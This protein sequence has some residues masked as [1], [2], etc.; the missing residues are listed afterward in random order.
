M[1][2]STSLTNHLNLVHD[3]SLKADENPK[4]LDTLLNKL[5]TADVNQESVRLL[6]TDVP[7]LINQNI[8]KS[9]PLT[10]FLEA[11]PGKTTSEALVV[12]RESPFVNLNASGGFSALNIAKATETLGPFTANDGRFYWYDFLSYEKLVPVY[13]TG[14]AAPLMLI[15]LKLSALSRATNV[16][17]LSKGS[18]WLRADL[19]ATAAGNAKYAGFKISSGKLTLSKAIGITSDTLHIT[20]EVTFSLELVLDNTFTLKG[21]GKCGSDSRNA[22]IKL[23]PSLNLQYAAKKVSVSEMGASSW[24]LYG[25]K[26]QFSYNA[27]VAVYNADLDKILIPLKSDLPEFS[28]KKK[29]SEFFDISGNALVRDSVW[30]LSLAALDIT[31]PFTIRNNG[32]LGVIC[33]PGLSSRWI[34]LDAN[35]MVDLKGPYILAEPG[36][37]LIHEN[38]ADFKGLKENYKLWDLDEQSGIKAG[39]A[40]SFMRKRKLDYSCAAEGAEGI[41]ALADA[42]IDADKPIKADGQPVAPRSKDS[43]YVKY[44]TPALSQV[45][46][47]DQDMLSENE[48]APSEQLLSKTAFSEQ[49]KAA[50]AP[51]QFALEN[52]YLLATPPAA[53]LLAGSFDIDNVLIKGKLTILYG[54][55]DLVPT[56]PHPYTSASLFTNR[57]AIN[58][59]RDAAT[60]NQSM[61]G[62]LTS[63]CNWEKSESGMA[64]VNV[65]F[66]LLY[67][68]AQAIPQM[69][70]TSL[71]GNN[72]QLSGMDVFTSG[73]VAEN[74]KIAGN[75]LNNSEIFRTP[76]VFSLLDLSTNYDL[77]G[78]SMSFN[79]VRMITE[80]IAKVNQQS[81]Q[82]VTIEKMNLRTPMA[83]LNGFTLPHISWEPLVNISKPDISA[84]PE[85]GIL[86]FSDQGPSTI[87]SQFDTQVIDIDPMKYIK[88]F[89]NN[90]KSAGDGL[91]PVNP[92]P[93]QKNFVSNILF[94]LPNGK[95]SLANLTPYNPARAT[96]NNRHL[97]FIQPEFEM[98]NLKLK[99]GLQF[100]I[101]ANK[102]SSSDFPPELAGLTIQL[103]N[104]IDANG[105]SLPQSILGESVHTIFNNVFA[106]GISAKGVPVTHIDFSG[107]GAST[108]SN[109][110]APL[111]K[112]G[113]IA[114]VKFD[115]MR[116]RLSHEVVQAVS[117]IYPYGI[118]VVRTIT[119]Y[120]RN[121]AIIFREDSG[122]VAKSPGTFDFS[123]Q[124]KGSN[125]QKKDFKN[126]YIFHPGLINGLFEVCNIK[127]VESDYIS[128]PYT[129]SG[130]DYYSNS[131]SDYV[132]E[133]GTG[134]TQIAKFVGV[135]FDA[136]ADLDING[137]GQIKKVPGKQFKG[138]L[139][140]TPQ[141]V[142]IPKAVFNEL[143]KR[144]QNS[145]GG[146]VDTEIKLGG[147][148]Q[149]VQVGRLDVSA[150]YQNDNKSDVIF[151]AAAR[152]S[153][154]LPADGSW[155]IV[156]LDKTSGDVQPITN[157]QSVPIIREGVRNQSGPKFTLSNASQV[158]K[159]TPPD[160]LKNSAANFAKRF[161]YIQNTGTQKLLLTDPSYDSQKINK[162]ISEAPL[163]AD[164][165]RLLNSK[166]PFPNLGNAIKI[167]N[168]TNSL[169]NVLENGLSKAIN[170]FKLPDNFT[171]DIIGKDGD[172]FRMYIKYQSDAK[173]GTK[174]NTLISYLTDSAA[175]GNWKND[176]KDLSIVVDLASFKSLM[177]ISGDFSAKIAAEPGIGSGNAPQLKL[178]KPLEK[179]YQILEFLDNLDPT[180]AVEAVQRGL[181]I[182]MS[183][184]A[185]SWDYKFKASKEIPFVKFPFDPINYNSPTTPLKL[186]AYFKIGCY[187]NQ[188]I[189]IPNTIDQLMPSAGAFLE[190]G[191]DLRVMCVSL[192]AATIYATGRAE[193]GLAADLKSS[194]TLYF[195]FGFGV[196]LC[197]GLPVIGSV[198]VLYMVGVDMSLNTEELIVGAFIY[199]RGR[200]EIFGGIVTITI[201]IEAAGKIQKQLGGGPTS[202]I[203][204][205]TFALDISIFWVIDINFTETWEETRQIA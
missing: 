172:P 152:G 145:L 93:K 117:M 184:S 107:Y 23:P 160:A 87:F 45:M 170:D 150:S 125:G 10:E 58:T 97:D 148:F 175:G 21:E 179:I 54:L 95:I 92:D 43:I 162:L 102:A 146:N 143:M 204:M 151:V 180:N 113:D 16:Y 202:C 51:Y 140:L 127:E 2:K 73:N 67:N 129:P 106:S 46:V 78:V 134:N 111:A 34:G 88:R 65:D 74:F 72:N 1:A 163:L 85:E 63:V 154:Q 57:R 75:R 144:N 188:P 47:Y 11:K 169:T 100:R 156:E 203:A 5:K 158:S 201:A 109:W 122:W 76:N 126:P 56:L 114:Q 166:G 94:A 7:E 9:N 61:L 189:K 171:F 174:R 55:L 38:G 62:L 196:E 149:K 116:G 53:I 155:S 3:V 120:R 147:S 191:A 18:I 108:Y 195:K 168:V 128:I 186:D 138:Y 137:K 181:K 194:P 190:L 59:F 13:V 192:A 133:S 141:G 98:Q 35:A 182:A 37:F 105:N 25:D 193:V 12:R 167:E 70:G 130:G 110:L 139:Q 66:Q 82:L 52:A 101:S 24:A 200:A 136:N 29:T 64:L 164:S 32:A 187:F 199:F 77:L 26:R 69:A 153:V 44:V 159:V 30:C 36:L 22:E 119:F 81:E 185:D 178:A 90:L 115:V 118:C 124:A 27:K 173:N 99:G 68:Q 15:P 131:A 48:A 205:C 157:K 91:A 71:T 41:S 176:L 40:L 104:L 197:V 142:P 103:K 86:S 4:K 83:L 20:V 89:K 112:F 177:T 79:Q 42:I 198:A 96:M 50:A 165:F 33:R 135:T 17:T 49:K 19:F 60:Y 161:G 121:N 183:N 123:F 31:K 84:D 6:K 132:H 14:D 28:I 8:S 80:S 39:M